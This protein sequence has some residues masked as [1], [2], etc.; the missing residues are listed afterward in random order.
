M[1]GRFVK[2][3][4]PTWYSQLAAESR[5]DFSHLELEGSEWERQANARARF[6][7]SFPH[8]DSGC[9]GSNSSRA[10]YR[11]GGVSGD[12]ENVNPRRRR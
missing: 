12:N 9:D 10:T 2:Y 7:S 3:G 1:P 8:T 4:T 11:N 5:G 6:W